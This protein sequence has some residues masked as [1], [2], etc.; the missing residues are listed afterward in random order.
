[1]VKRL[2]SFSGNFVFIC[3]FISIPF[4]LW[5]FLCIRSLPRTTGSKF[6]GFTPFIPRH[7]SMPFSNN[8]S[9]SEE[10]QPL[11]RRQSV[12]SSIQMNILNKGLD[13]PFKCPFQIFTIPVQTMDVLEDILITNLFANK[14]YQE[15][16]GG[17]FL[18]YQ[19]VLGCQC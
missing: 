13:L 11:K 3:L 5:L 14:V 12:R 4:I 2:Y 7:V 1:M 10:N 9:S 18:P 17:L 8:E 16:V 6:S 19:G 15:V